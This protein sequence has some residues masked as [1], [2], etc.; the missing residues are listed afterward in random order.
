MTSKSNAAVRIL[1]T[2]AINRPDILAVLDKL[3]PVAQLEF[4]EYSQ[5][6]SEPLAPERYAPYGPVTPWEQY[7][8][9]QSLL[10]S[11]RPAAIVLFY[12]SSLNQV[13]LRIAAHSRAIPTIHVEHGIRLSP[14]DPLARRF[15]REQAQ[16]RFSRRR[17]SLISTLA[18]YRFALGTWA[19]LTGVHRAALGRYLATVGLR[20]ATY[21]VLQSTANIRRPD[22][23][24]SFSEQCLAYHRD[25][26]RIP[27]S[28]PTKLV[29]FPQ[30]D[31]FLPRTA[32]VDPR[33]AVL[34]DHQFHNLGLFGW[35]NDFRTTWVARIVDLVEKFDLRLLVKQHPEDRS[36]AW[37]RWRGHPRIEVVDRDGLMD[38][39]PRVG[40][41]LGT[42][43]TLQIPLAAM[44]HTALVTLE[45]HPNPDEFPSR[46][47]VE[48]GAATAAFTWDALERLISRRAELA[49]EQAARK[50]AFIEKFLHKMDGRAGERLRDALMTLDWA[51]VRRFGMED[52]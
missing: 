13:A 19:R 43:S 34:I 52:A 44:P 3:R 24:L 33:L 37:E 22:G 15:L 38:A 25:V 16:K 8:S 1:A 5:M 36:G 2:G 40:L 12:V 51:P 27:G 30:F 32:D 26:D 35:T 6:Y 10:D 7:T 20:G 45:I 14:E 4:V 17:P 9:A 29:G 28:W 49:R 41:I 21:E 23:Y 39:L 46:S 31:E 42:F 47:F 50:D 18:N 48:T 11:T